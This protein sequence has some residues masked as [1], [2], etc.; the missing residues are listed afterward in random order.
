MKTLIVYH[1]IHHRNTEKIAKVI[2]KALHADTVSPPDKLKKTDLKKY[3]LVGFGSGIYFSMHHEKLFDLIDRLPTQH[4]KKAFLF[5]TSGSW[6]VKFLNDFSLP[7]KTKLRNKGFMLI[8]TF[9]CRGYDTVG[10]LKAI[11]GLHKGRP[12]HADLQDAKKFALRLKSH[13]SG[14]TAGKKNP[15]TG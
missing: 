14:K 2:A 11:G 1:S 8:G 7:L 6:E 9:T 13:L 3:D 12:D 4:N 5:A 15:D 10:P